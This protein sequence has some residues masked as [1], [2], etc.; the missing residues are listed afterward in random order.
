MFEER[1]LGEDVF[2][3]PLPYAASASPSSSAAAKDTTPTVSIA[4]L[5]SARAE[6]SSPVQRL[7]ADLPAVLAQVPVELPGPQA[8]ADAAALLQV[9][10]Q[11]HAA[12]L[13]RVR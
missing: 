12:A 10:E 8:L 13:G 6:P 1:E 5:S 3:T 11:L 4:A 7:L 9:V 2:G